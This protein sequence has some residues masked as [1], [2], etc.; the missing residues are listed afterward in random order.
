MIFFCRQLLNVLLLCQVHCVSVINISFVT[1]TVPMRLPFN[2]RHI[3]GCD[4]VVSITWNGQIPLCLKLFLSWR[5]NPN[6]L[7]TESCFTMRIPI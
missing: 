1:I 6:K 3:V 2:F 5:V 4:P 7:V